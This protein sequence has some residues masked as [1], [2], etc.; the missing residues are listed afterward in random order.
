LIAKKHQYSVVI[1]T[2]DE[3]ADVEYEQIALM[4]RRNVEGIILVPASGER[5]HLPHRPSV[6]LPI[7]TLDRPL[8]GSCYASVVVENKGGARLV[9]D[10]LIEHGCRRIVHLC[11][12]LHR[13]TLAARNQGYRQALQRANLIPEVVCGS[14]SEEDMVELLLKLQSGGPF[15]LFC[16]N[17]LMTRRALRGLSQ[18]NLHVPEDVPVVGFDDFETADLLKPGITV[19]RQ[20]IHE[21]GRT[22]AEIL[23]KSFEDK[24]NKV[25]LIVLPVELIVRDSC[26]SLHPAVL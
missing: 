2:S 21:L 7:V 5:K 15:A 6:L 18:L 4:A 19:V 23:F 13:Y 14:F 22:G 3:D 17:N 1:T 10:H 8:P 12:D 9:V 11:A 24:Q 16:S 20:P 26:G 25:G